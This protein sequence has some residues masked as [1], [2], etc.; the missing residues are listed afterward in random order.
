MTPEELRADIPV[1][2]ETT[3]LNWG[4]SG[5]SPRRVVDAVE[6]T[7]ESHE[8]EASTEGGMYETAADVFEETRERV[9]SFAGVDPSEIALTQS[10][11]DGINRVA[12][13]MDWNR[14]DTVVATDLEHSAGRLPWKRLERHAG[15][16][17]RIVETD[18]GVIDLEALDTALD[19][20]TLLCVSALDWLYGRSHPVEE[21]VAVAHENDVLV[22][23]DAV[24]VPGQRPLEAGDWN[25]DFVAAAG[26]KWLLGPWGAGFLY[27][28]DRVVDS[29]EPVH[30]G[31]RSVRE[32]NAAQYELKPG[33]ERFEVG[34]MSPAP[35]A[36]LG[37]AIT[38]VES[39]G[40]DVIQDRIA[41]LT[42]RFKDAV[43]P[44]RL[45]SPETFH[46]GLVTVRVEDAEAVVDALASDSIRVR[47]LPVPDSVR[48][49]IH[50]A[51]TADDVDRVA[52]ALTEYW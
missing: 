33:A 9:A 35:Y 19:G 31:Y 17:T 16:E 15:I 13:A 34:T 26:H 10:T 42:A 49:S 24:Q 39:L 12:T 7:L 14:G 44:D 47:S 4:A 32:P 27:V 20:A 11:T 50:A 22:L 51:N 41:E 6:S 1:L 18:S 3:Y 8:F 21:I 52:S 48:V 30:I 40:L 25:A 38:T 28:S 2:S 37:A 45:R 36:G 29:L 43:P 5:P 46:S 23:V